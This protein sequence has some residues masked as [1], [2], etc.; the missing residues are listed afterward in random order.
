MTPFTL[1]VTPVTPE[2]IVLYSTPDEFYDTASVT[3]GSTF[4]DL[5]CTYVKEGKDIQE[6]ARMINTVEHQTDFTNSE[7]H[8]LV[9]SSE[10]VQL[11]KKFRFYELR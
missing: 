6:I 10:P 3:R 7:T 5:L 4:I 9:V 2:V 1:D 8:Q 11:K